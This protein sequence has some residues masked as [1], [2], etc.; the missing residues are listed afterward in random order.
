[1]NAQ[2]LIRFF[3][4]NSDVA[5]EFFYGDVPYWTSKGDRTPEEFAQLGVSVE[6]VDS[7]GGEGQEDS[8]WSVYRFVSD[9]KEFYLKFD[10]WYASH[11]GAE[12]DRVFEVHPK[13]KQVTVYE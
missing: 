13:V 1:M 7:Y 3:E 12:F 5:E 6:Y 9:G 2:E 4:E 11:N 8:F 10:G